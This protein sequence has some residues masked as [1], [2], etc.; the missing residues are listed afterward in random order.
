M[1]IKEESR[2]ENS[3]I[4][5]LHGVSVLM[6]GSPYELRWAKK[7]LNAVYRSQSHTFNLLSNMG[8]G[9]MYALTANFSKPI[10][11]ELVAQIP[12]GALVKY[13]L[14]KGRTE[15][16]FPVVENA[17]PVSF[18]FTMLLRK[19]HKASSP[20]VCYR[21]VAAFTGDEC[22]PSPTDP[23]IQNDHELLRA[24]KEFWAANAFV[25]PDAYLYSPLLARSEQK[26]CPWL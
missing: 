11:H 1:H 3:H 25:L 21:V 22:P 16:W 13:A 10:G 7:S 23:N 8:N 15:R 17:R 4:G 9:A 12:E 19:S 26:N 6:Q 18:A 20:G 5:L 2:P 24:S 14:M